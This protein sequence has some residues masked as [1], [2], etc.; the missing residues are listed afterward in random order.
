MS[1]SDKSEHESTCELCH[2]ILER[3]SSSASALKAINF[4]EKLSRGEYGTPKDPQLTSSIPVNASVGTG[5]DNEFSDSM[6]CHCCKIVKN[7]LLSEINVESGL[8][9]RVISKQKMTETELE[10]KLNGCLI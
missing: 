6:L 8:F 10:A 2:G 1:K 7:D 4:T 5:E 3:S 9:N